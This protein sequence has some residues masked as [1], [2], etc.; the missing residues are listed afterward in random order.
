MAA[1]PG[2]ADDVMLAAATGC[3]SREAQEVTVIGE[4]QNSTSH[5]LRPRADAG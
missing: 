3:A 5:L 1:E 2:S 4:V